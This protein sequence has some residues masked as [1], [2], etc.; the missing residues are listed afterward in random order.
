MHQAK[1][2]AIHLI[3][4]RDNNPPVPDAQTGQWKSGNWR[5]SEESAK[6]MVSER[7][8]IYFHEQQAGP[9]FLGGQLTGYS[10]IDPTPQNQHC[11]TVFYFQVD[12]ACVGALAG[13][14][15]WG[16]EQKRVPPVN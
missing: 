3:V 14:E 9:A 1:V 8:W 10:R 6:T 5:V 13:A 4:N 12:P 16:M 15:G 2:P 11:L 7:R